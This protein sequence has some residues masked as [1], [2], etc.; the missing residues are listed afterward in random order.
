MILDACNSSASLDIE[1][2]E[3]SFNSL[4]LSDFP[5]DNISEL[6]TYALK[7][8]KVTENRY[9]FPVDIG[10]WLIKK[11]TSSTL[12]YFNRT[13][14]SALDHVLEM[15]RRFRTKDPKLLRLDPSYSHYGPIGVCA[16]LQEE[17][18]KIFADK[19]WLDLA[20]VLPHA[21][22]GVKVVLV[23]NVGAIIIAI[24]FHSWDTT[25]IQW[26]RK[27]RRDQREGSWTGRAN[28]LLGS[29]SILRISTL[30]KRLMV[31]FG[32]F[33]YIIFIGIRRRGDF[34]TSPT[35]LLNTGSRMSKNPRWMGE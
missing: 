29:I 32:S 19:D 26:T 1:G 2:V 9:A 27:L 10:S 15:E 23:L 17:Y 13:M 16:I 35:P 20:S 5:D 14:F 22:L 4:S 6:A 3:Q 28:N 18:S 34:I 24:S 12:T 25:R 33:V 8:I 11:V 30:L 7:F 31:R 21:N